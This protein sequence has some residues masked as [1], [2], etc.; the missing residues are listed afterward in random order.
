MYV[1][2]HANEANIFK[3]QSQSRLKDLGQLIS[4]EMDHASSTCNPRQ[5]A[6]AALRSFLPLLSDHD[7][8]SFSVEQAAYARRLVYTD[9]RGRF[10]ILVLRWTQ[11]AKTPIHGHN[12]WGSVGVYSGNMGCQCFDRIADGENI[13]SLK[14]T[15]D[16]KIGRGDITSVN[17]DPEGIHSLY[18]EENNT[19]ATIHIYGMDLRDDPQCINVMYED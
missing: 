13:E 11:G 19:A 10:S 18:V 5:L 16:I 17:P 2:N 6:E 3:S 14:M 9:P 15:L 12:A 4:S 8:P 1:D 7:L